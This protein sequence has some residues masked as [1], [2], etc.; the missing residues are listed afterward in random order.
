MG[1][2]DH[3]RRPTDAPAG[4]QSWTQATYNFS[5]QVSSG[6]YFYIVESL[7]PGQEGKIAKGIFAVIR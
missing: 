3:P 7:V 4:E 5:T 1:V 2:I 6:H